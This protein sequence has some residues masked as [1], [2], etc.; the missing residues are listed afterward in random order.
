MFGL[1]ISPSDVV[2]KISGND[3]IVGVK[4]PAHPGVIFRYLSGEDMF[5][6]SGR[7]DVNRRALQPSRQE[8]QRSSRAFRR[9]AL[10]L[11]EMRAMRA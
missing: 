2:V 7:R 1:G 8:L 9:H 6:S 4:D 5:L 3:L 10:H 11:N